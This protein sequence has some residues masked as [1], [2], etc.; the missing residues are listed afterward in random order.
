MNHQSILVQIP[1]QQSGF[2]RLPKSGERCPVSGLSRTALTALCGSGKVKSK[3]L[4]SN[5][6]AKRGVRLIDRESLISYINSIE[7]DQAEEGG[8]G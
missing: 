1:A 3:S 7:E 8:E 6:S 2:I 4:K 5:P